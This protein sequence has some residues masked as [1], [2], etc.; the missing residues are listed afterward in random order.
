MQKICK[1]FDMGLC[2]DKSGSVFRFLHIVHDVDDGGDPVEEL[3]IL[4]K[5][6][7]H[8]FNGFFERLNSG[9]DFKSVVI[10]GV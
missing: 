1:L 5:R 9:T 4:S 2:S 6:I 8:F 7:I 3:W 10:I